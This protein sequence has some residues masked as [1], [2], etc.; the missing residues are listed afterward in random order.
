MTTSKLV[1]A[2]CLVI[3]ISANA[4]TP[5]VAIADARKAALARVPGSVVHEKLKH[6]KG[7]HDLYYFKVK[8][9]DAK[10]GQLKKV[11]VDAESGKVV[12][13]KDVKATSKPED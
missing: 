9:K 11:E 8:P 5:K 3:S 12:E 2:M 10:P 13:V 1:G 7:G 6:K 4:G